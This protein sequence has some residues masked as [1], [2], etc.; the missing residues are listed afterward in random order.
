[1]Q[2]VKLDINDASSCADQ[3]HTGHLRIL[4]RDEKQ[5][6]KNNLEE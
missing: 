1:M 3:S 6:L 4:M 2:N 5:E